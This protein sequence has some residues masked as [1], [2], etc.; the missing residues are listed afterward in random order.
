M[1]GLLAALFVANLQLVSKPSTITVAVYDDAGVPPEWLRQAK[2]E[3]ERIYREIEVKIVWWDPGRPDSQGD[4]HTVPHNLLTVAIRR[5][6]TSLSAL[7]ENTMGIASG[8]ALEP[9]RVAYVFYG[10]TEQ[11]TPLVRGR[12]LGHFMAHE[13]GH[14]LL[15]PY[16]HSRSGLMRA[17]WDR[18]D[19]ERAQ[20]GLLRFTPEQ[21]ALIR[22][23]A[24]DLAADVT[25]LP[26]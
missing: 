21:A 15:P 2:G 10:Q 5:N 4:G 24:A 17:R 9:G 7:P 19:L 14:L 18:N 16:S 6:S 22:A 11:F 25:N 20:H 12:L 13:L 23:R 1:S 26:R 3:L 8:T